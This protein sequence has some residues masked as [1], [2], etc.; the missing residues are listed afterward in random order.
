MNLHSKSIARYLFL[1]LFT[2]L[3]LPST[4]LAQTE[5]GLDD[6]INEAVEPLTAFVESIVFFTVPITSEIDVPFV[7]ILLLF[8]ALFCTLYFGFPNL[9]YFRTS[10][11]IVRGK[12]DDPDDVGEVSHF[13]A[14][15]AAL[16]GTVGLG[17]I[18]GVAVAI[19][20]G[21][22]GAPFWMIL[23]GLFGMSSKF[24]E[25]TLGVKYRDVD[26]NGTVYGGPMYYLTKGLKDLGYAGF[27]KFLAI[28]F[29]VMC[30]GGS[31]GGGNMFQVNQ[32]AAQ[33]K[34]LLAIESGAFG[35][36]F[37]SVVAI[38]VG[39]VILGGIKRSGKGTDMLVPVMVGV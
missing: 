37:G 18:A 20:L 36:I 2:L 34:S 30:V 7:L 23:P 16:S 9:R 33:V 1:V 10:I 11:D 6:T 26:E 13:Q 35:V 28:F 5:K 15:T 19:G 8:G 4:S 29:A 25:C 12:Y 14:L 22:P 27:G 21:G 3:V 31:F 17:N 39:L 24:A 32:A 38:L